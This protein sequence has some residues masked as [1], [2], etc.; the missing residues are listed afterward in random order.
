MTFADLALI[1]WRQIFRMRR[2]YRSAIIGTVLGT[3]ALIV[4]MTLGD[5][6]EKS[7][8]RN[9][10]VMG[11]ATL[12]RVNLLIEHEYADD[13]RMFLDGDLEDIRRL[14]NVEVVSP[15][16]YS[17]WPVTL[18]YDVSYQANIFENVKVIGVDSSFFQL[19]QH[20]PL[21]QGRRLNESDVKECRNVCIIGNDVCE[22]LFGENV[23][24][25]GEQVCL[26]GINFTVVGRLG[27][28]DDPMLNEALMIPVSTARNRIPGMYSVRRMT[29]LPSGL[30][31]AESVYNEISQLMKRKRPLKDYQVAFEHERIAVI[32]KTIRIFRLFV[33]VA[34]V[35]TLILSGL[36][37]V[38]VMM[39]MVR[40]RTTEIG[41]RKAVGATEIDITAQ[42]LLEAL[43]V[44]L[45]SCV[46]GI[47]FGIMIV[48]MVSFFAVDSPLSYGMLL[49][50]VVISVVTGW[51]SGVASGVLPARTA[52]RLDPVVAM[53]FE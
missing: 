51:I 27:N 37:I 33:Y 7:I 31:T 15:A 2:R 14:P 5:Q 11:G 8:G 20:V 3:A 53:R 21:L 36:G 32:K 45:T 49:L 1:S 29:V 30:D 4:V 39:A 18:F 13:P 40:E 22:I 43:S 19:A 9:L 26:K 10:S 34:I 44:S 25:I 47:A 17:W 42:F 52:S 28:P 24:P 48:F 50:S 38:N 46:V 6:F 16:V 35:A 12:T 41:L 23:S